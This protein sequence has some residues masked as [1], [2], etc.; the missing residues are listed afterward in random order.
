ME[1]V[2]QA[3]QVGLTG[4]LLSSDIQQSLNALGNITGEVTN[5]EVLGY[6]FSKFC[7]G[8]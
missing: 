4:D 2:E 3:L 7:I 5:D 1:K 6:I 8:K